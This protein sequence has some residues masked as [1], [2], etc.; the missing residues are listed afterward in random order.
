[1]SYLT[2]KR[3]IQLDW[4]GYYVLSSQGIQQG[5]PQ[6]AGVYK[7]AVKS[8]DTYT[9]FYVGQAR[10]LSSR[11]TD[12]VSYSDN[13]CVRKKVEKYTCY[14]SYAFVDRA[15]DRDGAERQL[16]LFFEPECNDPT[17]I[18]TGPDIEINPKNVS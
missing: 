14:F 8:N 6:R 13:E 15:D 18:P 4:C 11:L 17:K 9:V 5:V 10:N 3:R 16:C 7:L 2:Q 1:M 12:H